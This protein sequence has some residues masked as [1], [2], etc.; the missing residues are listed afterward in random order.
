M[1]MAMGRGHNI[2]TIVQTLG[3]A[4]FNGKA[5]LKDNGF[6]CVRVL[7]TSNDYTLCTKVQN[8]INVVASR[9]EFG[10]TF[11][12]AVTGANAKIPDSANFL[13]H[14]F[15]E[16]GRVKG[17]RKEFEDLV[18]VEDAPVGLSPDEEETKGKF[19]NDDDAQA[20]LRSLARLRK[21]HE[22]VEKDD[23]LDD[24]VEAEQR[25]MTKKLL[26][27]LLRKFCDKALISKEKVKEKYP[28]YK[29][30]PISRLIFFMNGS[31]GEIPDDDVITA[32][33]CISNSAFQTENMLSNLTKFSSSRSKTEN[34]PKQPPIIIDLTRDDDDCTV[35]SVSMTVPGDAKGSASLN[36]N[37]VSPTK[38]ESSMASMWKPHVG[39]RV[40]K[41]FDD[42]TKHEGKS[43]HFGSVVN[44]CSFK[45][46]WMIVYD[47][48]DDEEMNKE[49]LDGACCLYKRHEGSDHSKPSSLAET[50]PALTNIYG[51]PQERLDDMT[52]CGTC[53]EQPEKKRRIYYTRKD[54]T[55]MRISKRFKVDVDQILCD[56]KRREG[57]QKMTRNS[58]FDQNSSIV[59]PLDKK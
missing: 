52:V 17:L 45:K 34:M 9:M 38:S 47:D 46:Y 59:L 10:D 49:E 29:V 51:V 28:Q 3:R 24:L 6:D 30:P 27:E 22:L 26:Q 53:I 15:R 4:T 13:R 23:I 50:S 57:Y 32:S 12:E 25:P 58:R 21:G 44:F 8:Y 42:E 37:V 16:L 7:T 20:L 19:W 55:V 33:E 11:A 40:A 31:K 39:V 1:I 54:D 48:G 43:L 18:D 41:L 2:S 56:N 14:T 36:L 5:T 35:S